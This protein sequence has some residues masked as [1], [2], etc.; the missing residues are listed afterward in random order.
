MDV[1]AKKRKDAQRLRK[2]KESEMSQLMGDSRSGRRCVLVATLQRRA[3]I[4][5][6]A[7][8]R[9]EGWAEEKTEHSSHKV[10][11]QLKMQAKGNLSFLVAQQWH[12]KLSCCT[13][14][15]QE[16][17]QRA[18]FVRSTRESS[19]S[20]EGS[21]LYSTPHAAGYTYNPRPLFQSEDSRG[22]GKNEKPVRRHDNT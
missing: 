13:G 21:L 18:P 19:L 4:E 8:R 7:S 17:P 6:S 14:S 12:V 3:T 22:Q 5:R 20:G 9:N 10:Q 1:K 11:G 16:T 2:K 15:N